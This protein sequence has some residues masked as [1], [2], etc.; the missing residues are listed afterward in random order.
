MARS[1]REVDVAQVE[2]TA[3]QA[4]AA[5]AEA[6]IVCFL[7]SYANSANE[8]TA[9]R[10]I[11]R[12]IPDLFVSASSNVLPQ[13]REF[14]RFAATA[15]NAFVAPRIKR[16]L[17]SLERRLNAMGFAA[18]ITVM[19]SN[20]GTLPIERVVQVPIQTMLSGPAAGVIG[21]TYVAESAGERNVITYDMGGTSTDV[22]L[23][24]GLPLSDDHRRPDRRSAESNAAD[25]DQQRGRGRRQPREYQ[26][27]RLSLG[28]SALGRR[29]AGSGVLWQ[30]RHGTYGYGCERRART[31][32]RRSAA[33]WSDRARSR[34]CS[35]GGGDVGGTP[36]RRRRSNGG[37]DHQS[38]RRQDDGRDQGSIGHA[39]I[40]SAR[41]HAFRLRRRR[42]VAAPR[43]SRRNLASAK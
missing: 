3:R 19:V 30:R 27:G 14:E 16:Y 39:R 20:G 40:R 11:A 2:H 21:A 24:A 12:E 23:G 43:S 4:R 9:A 41:L 37:R 32:G 33:R 29:A 28:R 7:H 26:C 15:V 38:S 18:P 25:R 1:L 35:R 36:Q 34:P 17:G 42:T 6:I 31:P 5:G 22:C 8:L 13:F 10:V